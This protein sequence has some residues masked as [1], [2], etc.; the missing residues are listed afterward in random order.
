MTRIANEPSPV[1]AEPEPAWV[2]YFPFKSVSAGWKII[3]LTV[4]FIL[5]IK[6][7]HWAAV[8]IPGGVAFVCTY[9]FEKWRRQRHGKYLLEVRLQGQRINNVPAPFI[10]PASGVRLWRI[11]NE[12]Y[13]AAIVFGDFRPPMNTGGL[14]VA[15]WYD[16]VN[17][18]IVF[19]DDA[20]WA[21]WT[22]LT[23]SNPEIDEYFKD[24]LSKQKALDKL[25]MATAHAW[26]RKEM[27]DLEVYQALEEIEGEQ[28]KLIRNPKTYRN[29]F[30]YYK[31][32]IPFLQ[33]LLMDI[34]ARF[35]E[36][37]HQ[38]GAAYALMTRGLAL[39]PEL[40]KALP[41][42]RRDFDRIGFDAPDYEEGESPV[43]DSGMAEEGS[44]GE[45][46]A[47]GMHTLAHRQMAVSRRR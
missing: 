39:R 24:V 9:L 34:Q 47:P 32:T 2:R 29:L 15:D 33:H 22:F 44:G 14:I 27:T 35:E 21:N 43:E 36:R 45:A 31:G 20:N 42:S 19:P 11:P 1:V 40:V 46:M 28:R 37:S 13:D 18:A 3:G 6:F 12:V 23:H 41:I 26:M 25:K 17:N 38:L 10:V 4:V 5:L 7:T 8:I 16:P 30:L